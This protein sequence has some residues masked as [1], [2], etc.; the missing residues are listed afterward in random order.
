[1]SFTASFSQYLRNVPVFAFVIY[2]DLF[3]YLMR[4]VKWWIS[5]VLC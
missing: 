4:F 5:Y 2:S 3:L 1:M